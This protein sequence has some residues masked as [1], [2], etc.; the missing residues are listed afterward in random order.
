MGE[1]AYTEPESEMYPR[2]E[3]Q[4]RNFPGLPNPVIAVAIQSRRATSSTNYLALVASVDGRLK[5]LHEPFHAFDLG[6]IYVGPISETQPTGVAQWNFVFDNCH[7]CPNPYETRIYLWD[8]GHKQFSVKQDW[9]EKTIRTYMSPT[10]AIRERHPTYTDL[11]SD[12]HGL[13]E[14]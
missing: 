3:V 6:G 9:T 14:E 10:E 5:L 13:H 11:M 7:V 12:F 8:E 2:G 1:D 4:G